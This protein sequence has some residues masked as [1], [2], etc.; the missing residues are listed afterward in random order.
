[1]HAR[2][3]DEVHSRGGKFIET[4]VDRQPCIPPFDNGDN[5]RMAISAAIATWNSILLAIV[6]SE[7]SDL[8]KAMPPTV[9]GELWNGDEFGP[10]CG[11]PWDPMRP[12]FWKEMG[13][14]MPKGSTI[15]SRFTRFGNE[16]AAIWGGRLI[17]ATSHVYVYPEGA[18]RHRGSRVQPVVTEVG[19][20]RTQRTL[21]NAI[22]LA[23]ALRQSGVTEA[24]WHMMWPHNPGDG[25][26]AQR[27]DWFM[28]ELDKYESWRAR[29]GAEWPHYGG[30][31]LREEQARM[32]IALTS[33]W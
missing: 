16:I 15:R 21:S 4:L 28:Y 29:T 25:A 24:Y 20:H 12:E 33:R 6:R 26:A 7:V 23:V 1:M 27:G 31:M 5:Q 13:L 17:K 3:A 32:L 10:D 11:F 14:T 2:F 22:R 19:I 18:I 8:R 9:I 30:E